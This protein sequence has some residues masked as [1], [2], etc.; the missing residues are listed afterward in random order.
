L[1][2]KENE[3]F[4]SWFDVLRETAISL[5]N[6]SRLRRSVKVQ[7][8]GFLELIFSEL[9]PEVFLLFTFTISVTKFVEIKCEN[10]ILDI[11]S[12]WR[13]CL[14]LEELKEVVSEACKANL[15]NALITPRSNVF[16]N[17]DK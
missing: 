2:L 14:I 5:V 1:L 4:R 11:R 3:L 7:A 6:R 13:D 10:L 12:W 9:G 16:N 17:C 8:R 15:I